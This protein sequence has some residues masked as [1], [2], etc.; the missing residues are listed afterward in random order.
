[1]RLDRCDDL[2]A[3]RDERATA[4]P[5]SCCYAAGSSDHGH[6]D[7][8]LAA[9]MDTEPPAPEV[10]DRTDR[11]VASESDPRWARP[12]LIVLLAGTALLYLWGLGA[13]GWAN[14]SIRRRRKQGSK[15]WKAFFFGSFDAANSITVDKPPASL[16]VMSL[17]ARIFGLNVWSILVPQA[18]AGVAAVGVL[19]ATVQRWFGARRRT[20]RRRGA[21]AHAGGRA[22]VPVQQPRRGAQ[23]LLVA[24]RTRWCAAVERGSTSG[25]CSP[26]T[27]RLRVPDED[28]PGVP[29]RTRV[30]PRVPDRR[31][32]AATTTTLGSS[33]GGRGAA[34]R[35]AVVGGRRHGRS[36]R[37]AG[38]TSAARRPTACGTSSSGTTASAASQA[39]RPAASEA[40]AGRRHMGADR[41]D[42]PVQ[43]RL[44]RRDRWLLPAALIMLASGLVAP[45]RAPRT[46]RT[47]AALLLWGTWLVV[48]GVVLQP[49][50]GDHPPLLHG[51]SRARDRSD[52][53]HRRDSP[54]ATARNDHRERSAQPDPRRD[55]AVVGTLLDRTP[56][57]HSWLVPTIVVVGL[58]A[59]I[60]LL[61]EPGYKVDEASLSAQRP[62]SPD[63]S[64]QQAS[65]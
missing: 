58:A 48:T 53:R 45:L 19:Y 12:C 62:S 59:A 9:R 5:A 25:W 65:P 36:R 63:C 57:W 39:T 22:D 7:T 52:R 37:R 51:G 23:L 44:R 55:L 32:H 8:H 30:H 20:A 27:R 18:L 42:P 21:R 29:R 40:A 6:E 50:P 49:R 4:V 34:R 11:T 16:W 1:M 61:F 14:A 2:C 10:Q 24:P 64:A 47:R 31:A 38:P 54:L 13:S 17:S 41:M 56:D 46:D 15:S 28:A 43:H 35:V 33:P 26:R 60:A 3:H